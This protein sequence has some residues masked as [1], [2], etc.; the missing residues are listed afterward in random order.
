MEKDNLQK[1]YEEQII[2]WNRIHHRCDVIFQNVM[3]FFLFTFSFETIYLIFFKCFVDHT[4]P[5][6]LEALLS[7]EYIGGSTLVISGII[8]LFLCF[9]NKLRLN[10]FQCF[11]C[12]QHHTHKKTNLHKIHSKYLYPPQSNHNEDKYED[13]EKHQ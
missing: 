5:S 11:S 7:N 13:Y 9:F 2:F 1:K 6:A 3:K 8:S 10:P 4:N 12:S